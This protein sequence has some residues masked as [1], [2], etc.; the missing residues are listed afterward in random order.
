MAISASPTKVEFTASIKKRYLLNREDSSK[1]TYHIVLEVPNIPFSVG[2][3]IAIYPENPPSE[4]EA[5]L[6][7]LGDSSLEEKLTKEINLSR[8]PRELAKEHPNTHAPDLLSFLEQ[9]P[10]NASQIPK[11]SPLLPRFYSIASSP[12]T[13]PNEIHLTVVTF[14]HKRGD[15]EVPGLG[16][17]FLC[18]RADQT[19]KLR[20]YIQPNEKFSLPED[21]HTPIIMIGPGTGIAPYRGFMEERSLTPSKNW[22]FFGERQE[23]KDFYY[24][25]DWERYCASSH[26]KLS[27]AFSRDQEEKIY[28]QHRMLEQAGELRDWISR[29]AVIYVCGDA[30]Q[31][32]KQVTATLA[33][34]L[35]DKEQV[36][37]LRKS[38]RLIL[39]VY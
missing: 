22:L 4:V 18:H 23:K 34:I 28:V 37:L 21:P 19:T 14:T 16:S 9:H 8:V 31:M 29:G 26:L 3:A 5:L 10:Y 25:E 24:K 17:E 20:C 36:K 39:D 33:E 15:K 11:F 6:K 38:D 32:A 7:I 30:K 2:D 12:K 1:R 13:N 35:G 27:T